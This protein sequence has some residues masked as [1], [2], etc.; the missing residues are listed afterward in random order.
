[1]VY[2]AIYTSFL[3][4]FQVM[5]HH[6]KSVGEF[7]ITYLRSLNPASYLELYTR[8]H[9]NMLHYFF[10]LIFVAVVALLIL[11][12]PKILLFPSYLDQ[13][14][15]KFQKF[16][17]KPDVVMSA[18]VV[19]TYAAPLI[20]IDTSGSVTTLE[21]SPAKLLI[22]DKK[23]QFKSM[24]ATIHE[25]DISGYSNIIQHKVAIKKLILYLIIVALP[26]IIFVLYLLFVVKYLILILIAIVIA[27]LITKAFR[28]DILLRS[29]IRIVF[30]AATA[31]IT[32]DVITMTLGIGKFFYAIP[33]I[34]GLD[35]YLVS[36]VAFAVY[37]S[38]G[39]VLV[40]A[41]ERYDT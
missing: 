4:N 9:R 24:L 13:Q 32:L 11:S 30:Y 40:A 25:A 37:I 41:R 31:M 7:F 6:L 5:K 14:L 17:V 34:L 1:M 21:G 19:F 20:I 26:T 12:L 33:F 35:L 18:P 28:S 38:V 15:D 29:V 23:I 36:L 10:S 2:K 27:Y 22:T 8:M 16:E 3:S 39:I